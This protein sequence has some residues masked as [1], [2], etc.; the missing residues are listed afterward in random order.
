MAVISTAIIAVTTAVATATAATATAGAIAASVATA[1]VAVSAAVGTV[2]LV[3][4]T[5][6]M[7]IGNEDLMFAGK[8]MGYV[9]L[10][11][12]LAGGLV[13]GVGG[14]LEGGVGT[15]AKG[16]AD[17]YAG[18]SQQ[19]SEGWNKGVGSWFS[20]G[21]KVAGAA[22][23][24]P[25]T[26]PGTPPAAG[27]QVTQGGV[28]PT[29]FATG[30]TGPASPVQTPSLNPINSGAIQGT[31]AP[32]AAPTTAPVAAPTVGGTGAPGV[33]TPGAPDTAGGLIRSYTP[34]TGPQN[35]LMSQKL[36]SSTP[37]G[38]LL[39]SVG[40]AFSGMPDWMKYS[41]MTTGAQ[42]VTGLAS[43]FFQGQQAEDQLAQ[44]QQ[45]NDRNEAYRQELLKNANAIPTFRFS[46]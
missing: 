43:G 27:S 5:I 17:T 13:G 33:V 8:I 4:G 38:G 28:N 16:F 2:G 34:V 9:G 45:L 46:H 3:V 30:G 41:M 36:L 1:V 31:Q 12:G 26:A 19:L 11:G 6:G 37:T 10:A 44:Q 23:S 40:N 20:G 21:E 7:A 29:D 14:L 39:D 22:G 42:G 15:F 25:G 32:I 18:Y 24:T 35:T